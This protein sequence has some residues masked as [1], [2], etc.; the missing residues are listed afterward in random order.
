[1]FYYS[2]YLRAKQTLDE[3]VPFFD[4]KEVFS[5]AE[6][7]RISEQQIGNFQNVQQVLG[8]F[9]YHPFCCNIDYCVNTNHTWMFD[10]DAKSERSEFG[11]F[12]YR[13]PSGE[14]GLDVY[15]RVSSFISTLVRDCNRYHNAGNELDN[16]NVVIVTHG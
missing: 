3:I 15:N 5:S 12:Y 9:D 4:E 6:E 2:P 16:L 14:A 10:S 1:M 8:E 11:R 7:P 13:F